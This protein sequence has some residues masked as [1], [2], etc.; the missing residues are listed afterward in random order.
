MRCK[1]FDEKAKIMNN[2]FANF[3]VD[4]FQWFFFFTTVAPVADP[5]K[6]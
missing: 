1:F 2:S 4:F 3:T 5:P 6:E